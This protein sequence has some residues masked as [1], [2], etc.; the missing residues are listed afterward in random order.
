MYLLGISVQDVPP[1]GNVDYCKDCVH[2]RRCCGT[3]IID[4]ITLERFIGD[5]DDCDSCMGFSED[6]TEDSDDWNDPIHN[7]DSTFVI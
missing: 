5:G 4:R 3:N 6:I 7:V 2:L 1:D